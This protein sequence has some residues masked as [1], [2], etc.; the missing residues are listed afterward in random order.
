MHNG[1]TH[2]IVGIPFMAAS[3]DSKGH[4]YVSLVTLF[5]MLGNCAFWY[6]VPQVLF[7]LYTKQNDRRMKD[8]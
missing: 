4:D 3:F 6:L 5:S 1:E 7:A 8:N 2:R